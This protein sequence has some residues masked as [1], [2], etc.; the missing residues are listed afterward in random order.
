[1]SS[2]QLSCG[3]LVYSQRPGLAKVS[4]C[5]TRDPCVFAAAADLISLGLEVT[6][7]TSL[8]SGS[9]FDR[10][11][12]SIWLSLRSGSTSS[13]LY[14]VH[15]AY[16]AYTH[17]AFGNLMYSG[18]LNLVKVSFLLESSC[19][20]VESASLWDPSL[21][22]A[23]WSSEGILVLDKGSACIRSSC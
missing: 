20:W 23:S 18:S 19:R 22:A 4:L 13:F 21:L 7:V 15:T 2:N 5:K 12:A 16:T 11:L 17:L 8:R 3:I 10:A 1:M 9:R 6:E 14:T